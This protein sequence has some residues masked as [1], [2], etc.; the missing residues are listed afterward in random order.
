[1]ISSLSRPS[2]GG[3]FVSL[4]RCV[5]AGA[6]TT[7][8]V[9]G[10]A[11]TSEPEVKAGIASEFDEMMK[12]IDELTNVVFVGYDE[13]SSVYAS[14]L[15]EHLN[16]IRGL[17]GRVFLEAV[18]YCPQKSEE[19]ARALISLL[20]N[21]Q[22]Q[23]HRNAAATTLERLVEGFRRTGEYRSTK[24]DEAIDVLKASSIL[25][26]IHTN[27]AAWYALS[28]GE[29]VSFRRISHDVALDLSAVQRDAVNSYDEEQSRGMLERMI[30]AA[31]GEL[32]KIA[33]GVNLDSETFRG[34]QKL[35]DGP[36]HSS[37]V[38]R[39]HSEGAD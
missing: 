5:F 23:M 11:D 21:E 12:K 38:G 36:L 22:V 32:S 28:S 19:M 25:N 15:V 33:T 31:I 16:S 14:N 6:F 20:G 30:R 35:Q 13:H 4:M 10:A 34:R 1:M 37:K 9:V 27:Q 26:C 24:G 8:L 18:V 3:H 29:R 2:H 39:G 17:S 7:A